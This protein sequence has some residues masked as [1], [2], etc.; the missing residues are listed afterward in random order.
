MITLIKLLLRANRIALRM[1][2]K[3]ED[4]RLLGHQLPRCTDVSPTYSLTQIMEQRTRNAFTRI[5]ASLI[6][7][8]CRHAISAELVH[9][10]VERVAQGIRTRVTIFFF[11]I[12]SKSRTLP[13][14]QPV[15]VENQLN[16]H[17]LK[18]Y[19]FS[20]QFVFLDHVLRLFL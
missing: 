9:L 16:I 17:K 10:E 6:Q 4:H 18:S 8:A 19:E 2:Q 3:K 11:R 13:L 5:F 14:S 15:L 1:A 20:Y 12:Y 7:G